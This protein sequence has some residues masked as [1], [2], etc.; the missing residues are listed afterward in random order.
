MET[1]RTYDAQPSSLAT[2]LDRIQHFLQRLEQRVDHVAEQSE[3]IS[4]AVLATTQ[5]SYDFRSH[6]ESPS[7]AQATDSKLELSS[8]TL[9]FNSV[10]IPD[11]PYFSLGVDLAR[12]D[13]IWDDSSP[14]WDN[15]SPLEI[16]GRSIA[17]IHWPKV[18][19]YRGDQRW[20]AIKQ[21]WSTWK[22]RYG[23]SPCHVT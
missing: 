17:L 11:P 3:G 13:R 7:M 22:V 4:P 15:S 6:P 14:S 16:R 5:P 2:T 20:T 19:Q 8:G 12:L 18:Y 9:H 10:E 21:R 23:S 1:T